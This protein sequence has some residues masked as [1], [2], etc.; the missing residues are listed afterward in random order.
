MAWALGRLRPTYALQV[1]R[2]RLLV[3]LAFVAAGW[4]FGLFDSRIPMPS[5]S[6]IFWVG[7]L[8]SPWLVLPYFAGWAQPSRRW[9]LAGGTLTGTA[10]MVGFF[11]PGG[12]W[13]PASITF[14][15][16]WLLVGVLAGLVY[17]LFGHAW[18]RSRALL[19][20]LALAVP[21][22]VEPWAWSVGLGYTQ[23]P[24]LYWYIE[25]AVGLALLVGVIVASRRRTAQTRAAGL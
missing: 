17:G 25:T 15:A 23:G 6:S 9:A 10:S 13:G 24:V 1:M 3:L 16:S 22:I 19:D 5:S 2:R 11:G 12:A 4:A 7:N 18:G 21:F 14:V 8:G 20:G